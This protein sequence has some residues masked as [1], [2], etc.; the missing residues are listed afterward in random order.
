MSIKYDLH[1]HSTASDGTLTPQQ[2]VVAAKEANVDVLA[3]TDHEC[4][5][6]VAMAVDEALRQNIELVA[7][8]EISVTWQ[9]TTDTRVG[10]G[11]FTRGRLFA[12]WTCRVV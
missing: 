2:L 4:V 1:S 3:L 7:G 5:D 12:S 10:F 11:G 8:V 9:S 6:G